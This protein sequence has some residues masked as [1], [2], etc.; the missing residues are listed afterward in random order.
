MPFSPPYNWCDANCSRCPVAASCP[1]PTFEPE[2]AIRVELEEVLET[3]SPAE[4]AAATTPSPVEQHVRTVVFSAIH[5]SIRLSKRDLSLEATAA[6]RAFDGYLAFVASKMARI[7][8]DDV[9][10]LF[11]FDTAPNLLAIEHA[12][13]RAR[14]ALAML[15]QLSPEADDIAAAWAS[16]ETVVGPYLA[17][18]RDDHRGELEQL[19][20]LRRAP[21]PFAT[22]DN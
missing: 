7:T 21:S 10:D 18:I 16:V 17:R 3:V 6:L 2:P 4:L 20:A 22:T 8:P 9:E 11:D 14:R 5:E 13:L 19:I 12:V 1:L 15:Q